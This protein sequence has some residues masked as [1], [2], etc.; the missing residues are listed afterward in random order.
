ML[1]NEPYIAVD[2]ELARMYKKAQDLLYTFNSSRP[3]ESEKRR[4]GIQALFGAVGQGFQV[5]P[6]FRCDSGCHIY[7]ISKF[8]VD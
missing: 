8:S 6:P 7:A 2:F 4:E 1:A 5:L 3:D